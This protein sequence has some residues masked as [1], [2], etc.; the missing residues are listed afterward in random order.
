MPCIPLENL[1]GNA[2]NLSA[3]DLAKCVERA[4]SPSPSTLMVKYSASRKT[5]A[6]P[7]VRAR[8]HSTIGGSSD[9]E[10]KELTVRP[11]AL[12]PGPSVVTRQTPV[13]KQPSALRKSRG[14]R[15][16]RGSASG[17]SHMLALEVGCD[18]FHE[19][20]HLLLDH[21]MRLVA[22]V[23]V[24]DHFLDAAFLHLLQRLDDLFR[25]AEQDR[26]LGQVLLLHVLQDVDDLHEVLHGRRRVLGLLREGLQHAVVEVVHLRLP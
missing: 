7:A 10:L 17:S 5:I 12:P 11:S 25:R 14:S 2:A 23:E 20:V 6:Q 3:P 16:D 1:C 13:G 21:R 9:T 26:A 19:P 8:L 15:L 24:E 22:D 4:S 18:L